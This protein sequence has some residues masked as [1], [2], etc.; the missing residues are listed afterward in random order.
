MKT[1]NGKLCDVAHCNR[2]TVLVYAINSIA[3]D[4]FGIA[5]DLANSYTYENSYTRRKRLY[6][7][8]RAE[9]NTRDEP[10]SILLQAPPEG[11]NSPY[12]IAC[13]TQ[14]N[15]GP[16]IDYNTYAQHAVENSRDLHYVKGLSADT[17]MNRREYF[18]SCMKKIAT[19]LMAHPEAERVLIP[20]GMGCRGK[21]DEEW[22]QYYLPNIHAL[23]SRL[24][25]FGVEVIIVRADE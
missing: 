18:Q 22:K 23:A 21:S 12:L 24:Q 9:V 19:T 13:V 20:E 15:Y 17:T 5:R 25:P 1:I 6:A 11:V 8:K 16:P 7:L 14:F 10:G 3:C 4:A 2:R